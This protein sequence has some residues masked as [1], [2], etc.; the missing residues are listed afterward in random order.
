MID[1]S[2]CIL[3]YRT[4]L[5]LVRGYFFMPKFQFIQVNLQLLEVFFIFS[6]I[7]CYNNDQL[8]ADDVGSLYQTVFYL[9]VLNQDVY[10]IVILVQ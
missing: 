8:I 3:E 9:S 5:I 6:I 7:T 1:C 10:N 4:K 2:R